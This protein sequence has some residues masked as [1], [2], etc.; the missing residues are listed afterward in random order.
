[1]AA[2]GHLRAGILILA[3]W[4]ATA[5]G[6]DLLNG[7][8]SKV[9]ALYKLPQKQSVLV[10]VDVDEGVTPPPAFAA[11]LA[12]KIGTELYV[13][14]AIDTLVP[15]SRLFDVQARNP[16]G[17]KN[18]TMAEVAQQANADVLL[19]VRL[20]RMDTP[21]TTDGTVAEGYAEAFVKV[22]DRKGVRLW[23]GDVAGSR[24]S[25]HVDMALVTDRDVIAIFKQLNEQLSSRISR[26]FYEALPPDHEF[27]P[28]K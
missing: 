3:A 24:I 13:N 20:T 19:S 23:P 1:M 4:A 5:G 6:C 27:A 17:Y 11:T 8:K 25:I 10:L 7:G 21:M 9:P 26:M 14:K 18:L 28:R 12:D 22:V 2:N 15:Q 16:D